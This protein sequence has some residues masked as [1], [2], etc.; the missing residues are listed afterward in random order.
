[1][2]ISVISVISSGDFGNFG[3]IREITG[4]FINI[5]DILSSFED[6][7]RFAGLRYIQQQI[8]VG[9]DIHQKL[10]I[11]EHGIKL[12]FLSVTILILLRLQSVM[13]DHFF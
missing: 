8:N 4:H 6:F 3:H 1:M 9:V 11:R 5:S 12:H 10:N 13:V 2:E 7:Q